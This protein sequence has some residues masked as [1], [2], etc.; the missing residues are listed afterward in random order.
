M[1]TR[2]I[3]FNIS[4]LF[5]FWMGIT[6]LAG[7]TYTKVQDLSKRCKKDY[8]ES[9]SL[10][11]KGE[12]QKAINGLNEILVKKPDFIDGHLLMAEIYQSDFSRNET[13]KIQYLSNA[14]Q[15]DSFYNLHALYSLGESLVA[16]GQY[17]EGKKC[18]QSLRSRSNYYRKY[19]DDI[20]A[21]IRKAE[22]GEERL[23]QSID[24]DIY[25]IEALNTEQPETFPSLN[26]EENRIF[27]GRINQRQEDIYL[28]EKLDGVWSAPKRIDFSTGQNESTQSISSDGKTIVFSAC[29]RADGLGS[30]DLYWTKEVDGKWLEP[31]NMGSTINSPSWESQPCLAEDGKELYFSSNRPG[32]VGGKDLY[33]AR[34]LNGQWETPQNLG[35]IVNSSGDEGAPFLH[36]S[37]KELYFMSN[38]HPGMGQQDIFLA[39]RNLGDWDSIYHLPPPINSHLEEVSLIT[40]IQGNRAYYA[41]EKEYYTSYFRDMDLFSFELPEEYRPTQSIYLKGKVVSNKGKALPNAQIKIFDLDRAYEKVLFTDKD[42]SFF[43]SLAADQNYGISVEKREYIIHSEQFYLGRD[44]IDQDQIQEKKFMLEPIAYVEVGKTSKEFILKNVFFET[45]SSVLDP[46]STKELDILFEFLEK[47]KGVKIEIQGHTDD[48]GQDEDNLRLSQAR[49]EAVRKYL[50]D[51]G[52]SKDRLV[53]KG[54]GE[55]RFVADNASEEGRS[56]NRRTSFVL[57]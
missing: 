28:A 27:F 44:S 11:Y 36:Y 15:L 35:A 49:A 51:R 19:Q 40:N 22:F 45:G 52:I 48:V 20:K 43:L 14:V 12:N 30:C 56:Q 18:I 31:K 29:Q 13:L 3:S 39:R 38:G 57:R 1:T 21:L 6:P 2:I 24:L 34:F 25:G 16:S 10:F 9:K 32:G 41:R 7:Q 5:F 4:L 37:G 54:Y 26:A 50:L 46:K 55:T 33:R 47:E 23:G 8:E 17:T 42:G 53:A